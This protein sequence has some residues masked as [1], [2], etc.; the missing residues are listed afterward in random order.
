MEA[1]RDEEESDESEEEDG[2]AT[3]SDDAEVRVRKWNAQ[4][5][6]KL[7][8][9]LTQEM[10]EAM[11][12]LRG[13]FLRRHKRRMKQCFLGWLHSQPKYKPCGIEISL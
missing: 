3:K 4:L 9:L 8:V 5:A 2:K 7:E 10:E 11:D 12:V 13:S 1:Q 6:R